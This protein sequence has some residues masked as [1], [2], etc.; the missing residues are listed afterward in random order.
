MEKIKRAVAGS[1]MSEAAHWNLDIEC[2]TLAGWPMNRINRQPQN[3]QTSALF[4]HQIKFSLQHMQEL[5]TPLLTRKNPRNDQ[6]IYFIY[7]SNR[8]SNAQTCFH[9]NRDLL[10]VEC[11]LVSLGF[12]IKL[13]RLT[14]KAFSSFFYSAWKK[15][16]AYR[17]KNT[18]TTIF[19]L[20]LCEL[21]RAIWGA[22][23]D[24]YLLQIRFIHSESSRKIS[25]HD[26]ATLSQSH[27]VVKSKQKT[28]TDKIHK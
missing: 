3:P 17:K 18:P 2:R 22:L 27:G 9:F 7:F 14:R 26:R 23:C 25:V 5:N 12:G 21:R 19:M 16:T 13:S 4:K 6:K 8:L 1:L 28:Y 15:E 10:L 24:V 11:M 20:C